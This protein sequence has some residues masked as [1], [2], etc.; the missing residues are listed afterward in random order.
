MGAIQKKA[1]SEFEAEFAAALAAH[2][3]WAHV[4]VPDA[5]GAQPFDVIAAKDGRAYAFD[6]KTCQDRH[7]RLGRAE[8][9]QLTAFWL[10]QRR[11]NGEGYF[12]V[13][14]DGEVFLVSASLLREK[15]TVN[16]ERMQTWDYGAL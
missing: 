1:G 15:K 10:W 6:C 8:Q 13:K 4:I 14:H 12:A 5:T 2:G 16:L 11:G 9:N 3:Y 7:F